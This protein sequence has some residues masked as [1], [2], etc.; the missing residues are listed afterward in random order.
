M[1]Q[2]R[3]DEERED[4]KG[5]KDTLEPVPDEAQSAALQPHHAGEETTHEEEQ[6]HPKPVDGVVDGLEFRVLKF[7]LSWPDRSL[8]E[9]ENRVQQDAKEHGVGPQRIEVVVACGRQGRA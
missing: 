5:E 6:L 3:N 2:S 7:V 4:E 1:G 9:G 8:I